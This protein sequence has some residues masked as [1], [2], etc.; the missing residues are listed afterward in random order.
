MFV[1]VQGDPLLVSVWRELGFEEAIDKYLELRRDNLSEKSLHEYGLNRKP[2]LK[3]FK[4]YKLSEITS[5]SILE[6][7]RK[8]TAEGVGHSGVNHET[9]LLQQVLKCGGLWDAI[10]PFFHPIPKKK[11]QPGRVISGTEKSRL[12]RHARENVGWAS[13]YYVAA[14]SV[15]TTAGPGELKALR[16]RDVTLLPRSQAQFFVCEGAKNHERVRPIPLES[17]EAYEAM[18]LAVERARSLGSTEPD[19]YV[20]PWRDKNTKE[21]DPARH[22]VEFKWSWKKITIAAGLEGLKMYDLRR[23][24]I[25]EMLNDPMI[26]TETIQKIAGHVGYEMLKYYSYMRMDAMRKALARGNKP[27]PKAKTKKPSHSVAAN[28]VRV[29]EEATAEMKQQMLQM[30]AKMLGVNA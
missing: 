4:P 16:I 9:S 5:E 10:K 2:L 27:R 18:K 19:H 20:F 12:L 24:K 1:T 25:T 13:A 15:N 23:T 8:R 30:F 6:Y 7:Q 14:I 21:Y 28:P 22:Q 3:F 17:D 26:A 11:W 29:P